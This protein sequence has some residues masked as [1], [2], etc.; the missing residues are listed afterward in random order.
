ML[1]P[2]YQVTRRHIQKDY[3]LQHIA[4]LTLNGCSV[5]FCL[6]AHISHAVPSTP[7]LRPSPV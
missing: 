3:G 5:F 1:V 2:I 6:R 4:V 7:I